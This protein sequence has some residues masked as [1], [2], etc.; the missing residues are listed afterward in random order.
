MDKMSSLDRVVC[1]IK[2]KKKTFYILMANINRK[3]SKR[4]ITEVSRKWKDT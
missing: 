4:S 2:N 1:I 3:Q